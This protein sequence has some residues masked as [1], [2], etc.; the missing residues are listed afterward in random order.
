MMVNVHNIQHHS[1][2]KNSKVTCHDTGKLIERWG[3]KARGPNP[4]TRGMAAWPPKMGF[5]FCLDFE[6]NIR[7]FH[8]K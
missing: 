6:I 2:L 5:L 4:P 3:R 1:L 8:P 7:T